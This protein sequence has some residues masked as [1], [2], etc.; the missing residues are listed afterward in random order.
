MGPLE[1]KYLI[2]ADR[3]RFMDVVSNCLD[4]LAQLR[5][6]L[7]RDLELFLLLSL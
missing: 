5:V 4:L 6:L 1:H 3:H 2:I 7:V